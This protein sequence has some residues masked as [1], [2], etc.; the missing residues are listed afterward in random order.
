M[1][2]PGLVFIG[3][4]GKTF[5]PEHST[6]PLKPLSAQDDVPS[7]IAVQRL[8]LVLWKDT[9]GQDLVEYSLLLAFLALAAV[10][11]LGNVKT[12]LVALYSKIGSTLSSAASAAS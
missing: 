2:L 5:S 4:I 3:G 1:K 8:L 6:S 10:G 9:D 7:M 11:V 12:D